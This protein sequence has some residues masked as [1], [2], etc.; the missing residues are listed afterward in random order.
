MWKFLVGGVVNSD[1][2][3]DPP[4]QGVVEKNDAHFFAIFFG[5]FRFSEQI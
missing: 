1:F 4:L 5:I 3:H 2:P